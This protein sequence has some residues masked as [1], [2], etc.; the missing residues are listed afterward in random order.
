MFR[1]QN[2]IYSESIQARTTQTNSF[3]LE[4]SNQTEP[5]TRRQEATTEISKDTQ[6]LE[7]TKPQT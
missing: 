5:Q 6:A 3:K 4:I 7:T 1:S 2:T